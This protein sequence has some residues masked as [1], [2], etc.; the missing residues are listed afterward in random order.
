MKYAECG[1][2]LRQMTGKNSI[3]PRVIQQI[4]CR[5][6]WWQIQWGKPNNQSTDL[7]VMHVECKLNLSE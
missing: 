7:L 6:I 5:T 3:C 4:S 1:G 2:K